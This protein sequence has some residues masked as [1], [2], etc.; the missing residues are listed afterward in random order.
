MHVIRI[1]I[2]A[3]EYCHCWPS[4]YMRC[5]NPTISF[6]D[7]GSCVTVKKLQLRKY[8]NVAILLVNSTIQINVI[9]IIKRTDRVT[10]TSFLSTIYAVAM[11]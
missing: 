2:N 6:E 1:Q 3:N 9:I 4:R 11:L 10:V 5:E 8:T 7:P